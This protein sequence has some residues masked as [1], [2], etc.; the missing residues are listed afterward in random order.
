MGLRIAR[1]MIESHSGSLAADGRP[2]GAVFHVRLP[3]VRG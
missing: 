1:T 2:G 3:L